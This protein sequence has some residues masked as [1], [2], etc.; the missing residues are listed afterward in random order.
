M[1]VLPRRL[2]NLARRSESVARDVLLVGFLALLA[3]V[4]ILG[5]MAYRS[6]VE[7]QAEVTVLRQ[8]EVSQARVVSRVR[9]TAGKIQAQA[10]TVLSTR[11]Q[12]FA[13]IAARQRL[14]TLKNEM[15]ER[16]DAAKPSA[17]TNTPQW[18]EFEA[19]FHAYWEKINSPTANDWAEERDR[20]MAALAALDE[21]ATAEQLEND[22]RIEELGLREQRKEFLVTLLVLAVSS[23]VALLTLYE[24]RRILK[25]LSAAYAETSDSRDYLQSLL[26]SMHSGVL[27]ITQDGIVETISESFR[28]QVGLASAATGQHYTKLLA[29]DEELIELVARSLEASDQGSHY[30]GRVQGESGILLDVFSSPLLVGETVRGLILV[31]V[32]VTEEVRAQT[33]LQRN[34]AL[35]AIGQMTA[36][37]AHEIKNPLGS[38]RFAAEV[39]KRQ[40]SGNGCDTETIAVIERSVD[41]LA[42]VVAELSDYARPKELQRAAMNLNELL[43][44]IMPM[45]AD[46]LAAKEMRIEREY[47]TDLPAGQFDVT[48]LKKLFLNLIINAIEA[49]EPGKSIELRTNSDGN[50]QVTVEIVD[51]GSGMD[52]E[53]MRRLFEPFYTTKEK[54]TGLGMAIARKITELHHGELTVRSQK[55]QG[56]TATVRLPING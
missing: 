33:E 34:R 38:I 8:T 9:E 4:T 3:L 43:D 14:K 16:I 1:P 52:A 50:G 42:T 2:F 5:F 7:M 44:E 55:G 10:Q 22:K 18:D 29:G 56:T 39:L 23:V 48:E 54:G 21:F 46:R 17:L 15:D 24:I 27:V 53:T 30:R 45:V 26:D 37:I 40:P 47:A 12:Q 20:M 25:Q 49:S 19:A 11:D 13:A 28:R 36:Q 41:H 35:S 51:H 32:D 31:F 6:F